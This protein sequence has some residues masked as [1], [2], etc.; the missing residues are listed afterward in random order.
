MARAGTYMEV[1]RDSSELVSFGPDLRQSG[2]DRCGYDCFNG[3]GGG[4]TA[5]EDSAQTMVASRRS[6]LW[7]G[8]LSMSRCVEGRAW[9]GGVDQLLG[10]SP[11][12]VKL[13]TLI[14]AVNSSLTLNAWSLGSGRRRLPAK[15]VRS[16]HQ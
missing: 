14:P 7:A 8:R 9:R 13:Q 12:L 10:G 16:S 6:R 15:P 4:R 5:A 3:V 2:G 1:D 11:R